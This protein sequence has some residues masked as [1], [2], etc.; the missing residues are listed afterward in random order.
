MG[1]A[2]PAVDLGT[3]A[4]A[5]SIAVG[6]MHTCA[7]LTDGRVKCWGENTTGALGLGDDEDRGDEPGET[8]DA[9]PAVDLGTDAKVLT[10]AVGTDHSCVLLMDGR[11]KCWGVGIQGQLGTGDI[12]A[13]GDDPGE[14]GDALPAVDLG[15]NAKAISITSAGYHVCA[16]LDDGRVKCWGNGAEGALGLGDKNDRG[17]DPGEMGDALPAVDLGSGT[18][19]IEIA[20]SGANSCALLDEGRVKCWGYNGRGKLGLGDTQNRGDNP[21]EMGDQLPFID[22][23]TGAVAVA[24]VPGL[25]HIC[26]LLQ[27]GR[28]KCWGMNT[29]GALGIGDDE[30]RGDEPGEMGDALPLV[31]LGASL[32]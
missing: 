1:D 31:D 21:A 12:E 8:G 28:M 30:D 11:V 26:A 4:K 22:L 19:V 10:I 5:T 18:K 24:V 6:D 29:S 16:L 17:D 9:L 15:T 14:M 23:G 25:R 13:R 32:W 2:L 27:E 20:S 3:G 7:L